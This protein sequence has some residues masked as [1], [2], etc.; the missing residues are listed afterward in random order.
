MASSLLSFVRSSRQLL[1]LISRQ[2]ESHSESSFLYLCPRGL[3]V[4]MLS[5]SSYSV[6]GFKF[7]VFDLLVNLLCIDLY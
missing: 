4:P 3:C 2:M 6:L 7:G 1:V 5:S